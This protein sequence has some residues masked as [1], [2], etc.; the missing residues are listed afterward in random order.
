ME[1]P[2]ERSHTRRPLAWPCTSRTVENPRIM[3]NVG[4][5]VSAER[6]QRGSV[7]SPP[8]LCSHTAP[9]PTPRLLQR[10]TKLIDRGANNTIMASETAFGAHQEDPDNW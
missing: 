8:D 9:T 10:D 3:G 4:K 2:P 1:T 6:T 5:L 7:P